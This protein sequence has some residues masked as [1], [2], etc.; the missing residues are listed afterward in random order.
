M[1]KLGDLKEYKLPKYVVG[2][3]YNDWSKSYMSASVSR[4]RARDCLKGIVREEYKT[5]TGDEKKVLG[6]ENERAFHDLVSSMPYGRLMHCVTN[7]KSEEF[8]DGCAATA[9]KNLR[10]KIIEV[11]EQ[12]KDTLNEKF[13]CLV[14]QEKPLSKNP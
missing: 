10:A 4:S 5:A 6:Q 14:R 12:E 7:S 8:E 2:V 11:S 9:W 1:T 3:S 13:Y